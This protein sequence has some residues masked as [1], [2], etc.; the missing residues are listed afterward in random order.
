MF[1]NLG[2]FVLIC[3]M[4]VVSA[5]GIS[6]VS[7]TAIGNS[8]AVSATLVETV[9]ADNATMLSSQERFISSI[10]NNHNKI[11]TVACRFRQTKQL[12][13]LKNPAESTGNL[14]YKG[15]QIAIVYDK[16]EGDCVVMNER[17]CKTV[18]NGKSRIIATNSNRTLKQIY[19]I[20]QASVS[21]NIKTVFS[22]FDVNI[23][24]TNSIYQV[25]LIPKQK[26]IKEKIAVIEMDF[27]KKDLSLSVLKTVKAEN[28]FV[29]YD[30]FQKS[31]N[32]SVDENSFL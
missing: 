21:G 18:V 5:S 1:I 17:S 28:D 13:C 12:P 8:T 20:I 26:N 10:E 4:P 23:S 22:V 3:V 32:K 6:T 30:F 14:Y 24:E 29:R 27:D 16:P 9:A 7:A 25:K 31:F 19:Q 2:F 11:T 15:G